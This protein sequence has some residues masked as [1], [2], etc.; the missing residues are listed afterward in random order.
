MIIR[1]AARRPRVGIHAGLCDPCD[2][3]QVSHPGRHTFPAVE[4]G[5]EL[6]GRW[7]ETAPSRPPKFACTDPPRPWEGTGG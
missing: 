5:T 6:L 4:A 2:L 1:W 3:A 7:I